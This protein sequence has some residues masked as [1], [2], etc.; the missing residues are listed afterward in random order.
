LLLSIGAIN[1]SSNFGWD[2]TA[3]GI[4][5]VYDKV[6]SRGSKAHLSVV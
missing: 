6:L 4:L 1:H 2:A 3:R 5:D